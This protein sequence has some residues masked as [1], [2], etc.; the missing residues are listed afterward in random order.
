MTATTRSPAI[1]AA[2][3]PSDDVF[4]NAHSAEVERAVLATVLDGRTADAWGTVREAGATARSFWNRNH[5]LL[6]LVIDGMWS[7]GV[8]VDAMT[9]SEAAKATP[10]QLAAATL[11][12]MDGE[13][14]AKVPQASTTAYD[15]SVLAAIGGFTALGDLAASYAAASGLVQNAEALAG[16]ERQ[17][18]AIRTLAELTRQAQ[19]VGGAG[20][21]TEIADAAAS[22]LGLLVGRGRVA[23]TSGEA[24]DAVI[25]AHDSAQ[26]GTTSRVVGSW[27]LA[28]L[29]ARM[30]LKAGRMVTLAGDTGGGKTSLALSAVMATARKLGRGSVAICNL[31]QDGSELL[32]IL[33]AR[34]IGARK[35]ALE[36][37]WLTGEQH[38][39]AE[40]MRREMHALGFFIR[41]NSGSS[42]IRDIL[43]WVH[44]R[45][46]RSP[47]L[48]LVVLDHIGLVDPPNPK[49]SEYQ[50]VTEASK[51]LKRLTAQGV[52]VLNLAQMNREGRKDMRDRSTGEV[53]QMP[54]PRLADLRSSGSLEQDSDGVLFIWR[55]SDAKAP[56]RDV[57]LLS[58]KCRDGGGFSIPATFFAADGQRFEA[59]KVPVRSDDPDVR[60]EAGVRASKQAT[61]PVDSEDLFA[62]APADATASGR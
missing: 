61:A 9:V 50:T 18:Q 26:A 54:E 15:D 39:A 62:T 55:R 22:D 31:E 47:N 59:R 46:R 23:Q 36:G 35:E 12:E 60:H 32:T 25:A 16:Y 13:K 34:E 49:A 27:G 24:A 42:T 57:D 11:S 21:L 5:R 30:P 4:A 6:A 56:T 7:D 37:G 17:R 44:Q 45:R 53:S 43:G 51:A 58:P 14:P 19:G 2:N 20:R 48:H 33:I 52:C 28:P 1:V 8:R 29:D 41:D 40:D 3:R 38:S 10:Y